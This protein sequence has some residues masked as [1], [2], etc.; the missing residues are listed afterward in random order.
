MKR[1]KGMTHLDLVDAQ[2]AL[3]KSYAA[4]TVSAERARRDGPEWFAKDCERHA[5]RCYKAWQNLN[6]Y[7]V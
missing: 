3:L 4:F 5:A 1:I 2:D 7:I 6:E